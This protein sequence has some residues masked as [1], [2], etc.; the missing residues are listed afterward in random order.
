MCHP[1]QQA[2]RQGSPD[3]SRSL[4]PNF[5]RLAA[6]R[7]VGAWVAAEAATRTDVRVVGLGACWLALNAALWCARSMS[8]GNIVNARPL[9]DATEAVLAWIRDEAYVQ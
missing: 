4:L 1:G 5:T 9:V 2:I 8:V 6:T 7:P 3:T